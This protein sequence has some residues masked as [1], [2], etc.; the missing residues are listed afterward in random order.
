[1]SFPKH[2]TYQKIIT[3]IS[4]FFKI[5]NPE[6]LMIK[7]YI[8]SSKLPDLLMFYWPYHISDQ[9]NTFINETKTKLQ[10]WIQTSF[11]KI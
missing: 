2:Q 10:K 7:R 3:L 11:N 1:M 5:K 6:K 9:L 8:K 4:P